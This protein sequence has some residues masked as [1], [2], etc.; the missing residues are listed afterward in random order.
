MVSGKLMVA[1]ASSRLSR[2][3]DSSCSNSLVRS[4]QW[5]LINIPILMTSLRD[6]VEGKPI[7]QL[8]R[9]AANCLSKLHDGGIIW[10]FCLYETCQETNEHCIRHVNACEFFIFGIRPIGGSNRQLIVYHAVYDCRLQRFACAK[11]AVNC[12]QSLD[13]PVGPM[14][15]QG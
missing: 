13:A 7:W 1:N 2:C 9:A 5:N 15:M 11:Q 8:S 10:L 14:P 6:V 12:H 3:L 4:R